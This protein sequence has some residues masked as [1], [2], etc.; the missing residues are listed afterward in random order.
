MKFGKLI[1]PDTLRFE[2]ELPGP[3]TKVWAYL[4]EPDKRAKWLAAGEMELVEGGNVSLHFLHST[5]SDEPGAPPEKYK[6]MEA[7]GG[8]SGKV[9]KVFP[10]YLLSFTWSHGSE[11]TFELIENGDKVLLILTHR[12]LHEDLISVSAGWHTHLGIL[13]DRLSGKAP[14]NFWK[15]D[16]EMEAVYE[17]RLFKKVAAESGMLIRRPASEA[18]QAFIDPAITTKFWFTHSTGKLEKGKSVQWTWEMYKVSSPVTVTDIV[19]DRKIEVIWGEPGKRVEWTFTPWGDDAV[20]VN[21]VTDGFEENDDNLINE[22]SDT[23]GGF[24]W[25]LA[26]LK[27]WLEHGLQLNLVADRF[28]T[29]LH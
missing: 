17:E 25:V 15:V 18:F 28:P 13:A 23:A 19:P 27:A 29:G 11:V 12:K 26:G 1:A 10:P 7:G 22:V 14:A 16:T 5:L 3:V 9:L 21:V 8:F 24:C 4:T 2:R 20:F 6:N